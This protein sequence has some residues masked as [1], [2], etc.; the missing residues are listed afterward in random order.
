MDRVAEFLKVAESVGFNRG[1]IPDLTKAPSS[2][3]DA[4]EQHL[5]SI[6]GGSVTMTTS[7]SQKSLKSGVT[8]LNAT[9][10]SF[11]TADDSFKQQ[12]RDNFDLKVNFF[13]KISIC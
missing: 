9:G 3:L 13:K 7:S 12:V 10:N 2:L 1:E 5:T 8:A 4:L 11:G 6:E